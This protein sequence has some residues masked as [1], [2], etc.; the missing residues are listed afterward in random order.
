MVLVCNMRVSLEHS[1]ESLTSVISL[2]PNRDEMIEV[3]GHLTFVPRQQDR[4]DVREV[5]VQC[6]TS[7]AGLLGDLRHRNR[8]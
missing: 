8:Q 4:F 5:L 1:F 7:D 3:A 6:R 2:V